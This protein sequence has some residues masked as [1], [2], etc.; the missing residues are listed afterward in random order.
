MVTGQTQFYE[1]CE[2][3]KSLILKLLFVLEGLENEGR[4]MHENRLT[5]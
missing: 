4:F 3:L 5:L 2:T 1:I